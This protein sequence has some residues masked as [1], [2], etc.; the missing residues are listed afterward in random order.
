[1]PDY[2]HGYSEREKVRLFDQATTLTELLHSDTIYPAGDTVLEA[3]CGVGSQTVIL[4]KNSPG[5]R[6]TSIDISPTSLQAAATLVEQEKISNVTLR[7]ADIF[8]LPFAAE[9]FGH[10]FVCFVLE[11]LHQPVEALL[12]L[13]SVL[14]PGGSITVIEGDHGSTYFYPESSLALRTIQCLVELQSRAGGNALIGRQLYPLL[15]KAGFRQPSISPRMVYV[16]SSRPELVEGF[17]RN[18]FIAMVEGVKAQALEMQLMDEKE[19]DQGIADLYAATTEDG[20]FSYT[21]FKG[22]ALR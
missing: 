1:M 4:A 17:S 7:L 14:K 20:V 22:R 18:T 6:F 5:A 15:R 8:D 19:W 2:V 21:F 12:R 16:D 3:G 10:I 13:K 11:H 9:S